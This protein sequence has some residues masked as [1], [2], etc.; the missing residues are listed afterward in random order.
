MKQNGIEIVTDVKCDPE[1]VKKVAQALNLVPVNTANL[2]ET[3][4]EE[5]DGTY[6]GQSSNGKA[7][8]F[9]VK[10]FKSGNK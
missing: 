10:T 7:H 9:G 1:S 6:V 2:P 8:G 3:T 5:S 4:I